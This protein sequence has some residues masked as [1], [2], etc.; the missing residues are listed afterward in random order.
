MRSDGN[1]RHA[2]AMTVVKPVNQ[3]K[4]ARSARTGAD[5]KL[6]GNMRLGTGGTDKFWVA[7]AIEVD[8]QSH[9]FNLSAFAMPNDVFDLAVGVE[10]EHTDNPELARAIA[11]DH[12]IEHPDYYERLARA[13]L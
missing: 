6:A 8:Q 3:M 9:L 1:H 2:V 4:I 11:K 7:D 5:R 12:L 13:G 10:M